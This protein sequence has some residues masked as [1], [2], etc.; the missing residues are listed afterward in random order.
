MRIRVWV[1]EN[2]DK[3]NADKGTDNADKGMD[4]ANKGADDADQGMDNANKGADDAG[5]GTDDQI[6]AATCSTVRVPSFMMSSKVKPYES[7]PVPSCAPPRNGMLRSAE[8]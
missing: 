1:M 5:K 8:R 7:G 4:N 3:G 6:A 2:A